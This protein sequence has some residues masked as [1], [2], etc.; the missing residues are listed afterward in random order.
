MAAGTDVSVSPAY[1]STAGDLVCG[2]TAKMTDARGAA[3]GVA[4]LEIKLT[5]LVEMVASVRL[6]DTGYL[7]LLEDSGTILA[8][9]RHKEALFKKIGDGVIPGLAGAMQLK[10][11][12]T[13]IRMGE[14]EN[15][16]TVLTGFH[17]WKLLAIVPQDEVYAS[18]TE[19]VRFVGLTGFVILCLAGLASWG[20]ARSIST[21]IV[22]LAQTSEAL[23]QGRL[24]TPPPH[25]AM[26]TGEMKI[27]H[28]SFFMMV[29]N[30]KQMLE[31]ARLNEE[32]S[33]TQTAR[34]QEA[35]AQAEIAGQEI[36]KKNAHILSAAQ[37][38]E[39]AILTLNST[40][41]ALAGQ[42][43]RSKEDASRQAARITATAAAME[44]M[45]ST[46]LD[47]ARNAGQ[48][49]EASALARQKAES[50]AE[51]VQMAISGIQTV[52][53][54]ALKLKEDMAQLD[55][56]ARAINQI[57]SVISDIADQTNLLALNA[58][59][60]AARARLCRGGRRG[61]QTGGK[62]HD[63]HSRGRSGHHRHSG[64]HQAEHGADGRCG[65]FH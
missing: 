46:V 34:A 20:L 42:I 8:D 12:T 63:V 27:L 6:Y 22:C 5:S 14:Q 40:S 7:V 3:K 59:I 53:D 33:A 32:D 64:Q 44:E 47:I 51:V 26:F 35:L 65:K 13:V 62:N 39:Q 43:D 36:E 17:G 41:D 54:Q 37:H 2:V 45:N 29:D 10:D 15:Q 9:P 50:G 16:V 48:A 23:A 24:D 11:G 21:P 52:R 30:L 60:E 28:R 25:A 1:L 61:A 18:V 38:L 4:L 31:K 57:M 49:S 56:S 55:E 19:M 58:A